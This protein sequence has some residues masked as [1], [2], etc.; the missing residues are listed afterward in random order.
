MSTTR[1]YVL[2]GLCAAFAGFATT[3][4]K[5]GVDRV[6]PLVFSFWLFAF[7]ALFSGLWVAFDRQSRR[8]RPTRRAVGLAAAQAA[9]SFLAVWG[10]WSG[11][12]RLDPAVA[13]FLGRTETIVAIA[14]GIL[15]LGERFRRLEAI[16]GL[17]AIA[18]I[19]LMRFPSDVQ[20]SG[21][22]EGYWL[23][24]AGTAFFGVGEVISKLAAR[25]APATVFVGMRNAML[26]GAFA[27]T[28]TLTDQLHVPDTT[29]LLSAGGVA[30]LAPTLARTLYMQ[31]LRS[32]DLSKAA[33]I[34]QVQPIFAAL[35][36]F[37]VLGEI[38]SPLAWVGGLLIVIGCGLLV[39]GAR[40]A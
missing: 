35:L 23:V 29:V 1:G 8:E 28:A 12:K 39:T 32:I 4:G 36:A 26:M 38:P 3:V 11:V 10:F 2:A 30:L 6:E 27:I 37:L 31:A 22:A 21:A 14:M 7:A 9:F 17:V 15:V 18:G 25:E 16:G 40:S 34:N 19:V 33:V 5:L 13:S 24:L 20:E